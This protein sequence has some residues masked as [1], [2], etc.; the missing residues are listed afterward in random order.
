MTPQEN[1]PTALETEFTEKLK[2]LMAEYPTVSM[3]VTPVYNIGIIET[4]TAEPVATVAETV[5][6]V[7]ADAIVAQVQEN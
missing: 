3:Q 1:K 4:K 6:K 5:D 7:P 2:A